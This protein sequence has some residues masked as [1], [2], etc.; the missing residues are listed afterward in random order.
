MNVKNAVARPLRHAANPL[1]RGLRLTRLGARLLPALIFFSA[2]AVSSAQQAIKTG[3]EVGSTVP[4]FEAPD[5]NG[6]R[7]N[8]QEYSWPQRGDAGFLPF[9]GLVTVLQNPARRAGTAA[10]EYP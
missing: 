9:G 5:Q 6:Q 10:W 1:R 2:C 3:P 4:T 7:Q 8:L